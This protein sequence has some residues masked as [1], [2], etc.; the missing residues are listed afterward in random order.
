MLIRTLL[1]LT[2][3]STGEGPKSSN[4]L[5]LKTNKLGRATE[6]RLCDC[7]LAREFMRQRK[8]SH[9]SFSG[10]MSPHLDRQDHSRSQQQRSGH[11]VRDG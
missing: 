1:I 4:H 6:S 7:L 8:L 3:L 5:G 10:N 11:H 2:E 9:H